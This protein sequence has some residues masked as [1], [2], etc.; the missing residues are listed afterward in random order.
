MAR[1]FKVGDL[2]RLKN[3]RTCMH[4]VHIDPDTNKLF[5]AYNPENKSVKYAD[6]IRTADEFRL[7]KPWDDVRCESWGSFDKN[8]YMST[9][10]RYILNEYSC[11]I[12]EQKTRLS[13]LAKR[14]NPWE[15]LSLS[16]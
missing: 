12:I 10:V 1:K 8:K 11:R 4:I 15:T 5:A 9:G 16:M 2:V 7:W 6:T 3:G 13:I 14:N